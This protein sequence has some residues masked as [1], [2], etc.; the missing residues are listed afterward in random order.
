MIIFL[1]IYYFHEKR[2]AQLYYLLIALIG[3]YPLL[4]SYSRAGYIAAAAVLLLLGIIK[5]RRI[6]VV[7]FCMLFIWQIILPNAVVERIGVTT[8]RGE[9]TT[10]GTQGRLQ[11]WGLAFETFKENP[12]FG[13]GFRAFEHLELEEAA[14]AM[15]AF[16]RTK[17]LKNV[18]SAYFQTMAEMGIIG[19]LAFLFLFLQAFKS[20]WRLYKTASDNFLR[21][22]G[23]G[24]ALCVVASMITNLFGDRWYILVIQVYFWMF[25]AMVERGLIISNEKTVDVGEEATAVTS[26]HFR[27][28]T[29]VRHGVA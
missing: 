26:Q 3:A 24:F 27:P 1:A 2:R 29:Q 12:L 11:M 25:W 13:I 20:G 8:S 6:L 28:A 17:T 16:G 9:I 18:H 10:S 7:G 15:D 22:L 23:L 21:G 4:F 14:T 19:L 5:D